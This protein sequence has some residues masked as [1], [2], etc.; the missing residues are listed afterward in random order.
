MNDATL[1]R[2][3]EASGRAEQDRERLL[4]GERALA[5]DA[6]SSRL[7]AHELHYEVVQTVLLL[8]IH[9]AHDV[10][11]RDD[12]GKPRLAFE[13]LDEVRVVGDQRWF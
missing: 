7:A 4:L 13:A 8:D 1:V 3:G 10:L 2:F 5:A 6:L 12:R 11:V 9:H